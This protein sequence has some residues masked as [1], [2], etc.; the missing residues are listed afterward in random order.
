M[1]S[2]TGGR[3]WYGKLTRNSDTDNLTDGDTAINE[4]TREILGERPWPFLKKERSGSTTTNKQFY[5]L[6]SNFARFDSLYVKS[7]TTR[8]VPGEVPTQEQW[9][10]LNS[11]DDTA[12]YPDWYFIRDGQV[13]FYPIPSNGSASIHITYIT[14][15]K[16]LSRADYAS[17]TI[18]QATNGSTTIIGANTAW[19]S[20]MVG[21]WIRLTGSDDGS[22]GDHDWYEI[23]S[24]VST[25]QLNTVNTYQGASL[26]PGSSYIIGE[27]SLIPGD[28]QK[29]PVMLAASEN[30]WGIDDIRAQKL[31]DRAE[32]GLMALRNSYASQSNKVVVDDMDDTQENPNLFPRSIN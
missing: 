9:D 20:A 14:Q 5:D 30:L 25:T 7:G 26:N 8:Y 24:V 2:Y 3:N 4:Y 19:A 16:D 6:P 29:L 12:T 31:E 28:Y 32:R 27:F 23:N 1:L 15:H 11:S 22:S 18:S 17:G 13:G 10:I 21:R